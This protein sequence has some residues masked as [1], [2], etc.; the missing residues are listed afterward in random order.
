[1]GAEEGAEGAEGA[2]LHVEQ[3]L[4]HGEALAVLGER[5]ALLAPEQPEGR[6]VWHR[7]PQRALDDAGR[8]AGRVQRGEQRR[9][10]LR[11]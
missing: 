8:R 4:A 1:M 9:R 11:R 3:L 6:R 2:D 5:G 7:L 10:I